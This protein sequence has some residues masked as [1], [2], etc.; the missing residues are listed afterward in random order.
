MTSQIYLGLL[1]TTQVL[2]PPSLYAEPR[3]N[4]MPCLGNACMDLAFHL[5]LHKGGKTKMCLSEE[6][7]RRT[8]DWSILCCCAGAALNTWTYTNE[9][10]AGFNM[11]T[12]W[13]YHI[14]WFFQIKTQRQGHVFNIAA[15]PCN[16]VG[17]LK[18]QYAINTYRS[19]QIMIKLCAPD[20][21]IVREA[22]L[23]VL[24]V[25][26][27]SVSFGTIHINFGQHIY[28]DGCAQ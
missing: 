3:E 27:V 11:Q 26:I 5:L 1:Y 24:V 6:G 13:W 28:M 23:T 20:D 14:S 17:Q 7:M 4:C 10:T 8:C 21:V 2:R 15:R 25:H 22:P 19:R 16:R 9:D 12:C 18:I